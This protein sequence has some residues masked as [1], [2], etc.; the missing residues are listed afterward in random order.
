MG[1]TSAMNTSLNGLQL[2]EVS[3]DVLGNNIANAGTNGFKASTVR[4]QT[5]LA[6]TLS[7]GSRPTSTQGGTNPRQIGLGASVSVISKDFTQGSVTNSS[8]PSDLAIQGN[9]FFILNGPNGRVYSRN[10]NFSLNSNSKL[11]NDQGMFVMGY[12]VDRDFNVVKTQL[13]PMSIPIGNLNIA[14]QTTSLSLTG[15]LFPAGA[16]ATQGSITTSE[17]ITDTVAA[18]PATGTSLLSDLENS[19]GNPLFTVGQNLS[20]A[21]RKG[22]RTVEAGHLTVTATTTVDDLMQ[23]YSDT[24]GIQSGGTIPNDGVTGGQ[25]GISISGGQISIVGNAG[26]VND[27]DVTVGDLVSG[28]T[29]VPLS[30]IKSQSANGESTGTDF[31]IYD[32]LGQPIN[33]RVSS[34]LEQINPSQ[35]TYRYYIESPDNAGGVVAL[36][37]GTVDFDSLGRVSN[38]GVATFSL[39][40]S[41]TAAVSP[42]Q[43]TIDFT[44]IT[45][46]STAAAG[47]KLDLQSQNGAPPG[48]LQNFIIDE[49]GVVN[50][51]FDNGLIRP[52][53]QVVL[54]RFAN[55][56]GLIEDGSTTYKEGVSSGTPALV[57]PA[58]FGV[59]TIRAGAIELSNTDIGKSL[60]DLIVAST[61]YR[62]NARVIQSVTQLVDELLNLAR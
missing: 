52:L 19:S 55:P 6:R 62:G 28:T 51:V 53:G 56:E 13:V 33:V 23:F 10:G 20:L 14:Q 7:V 48:T 3:I 38:G 31:V 54:A 36:S 40:R 24:L 4:F 46:I 30:F 8:S 12:G 43:V 2:N 5:Q 15:A 49:S 18:A 35:T 21:P 29:V 61:N 16:P 47:S 17:V 57:E 60:V 44:G 37:N 32:S 45:G 1:L 41:D 58:T 42:M 39:D 25:P 27:I 22:G 59:G 34:V 50:G 26:S 9:G 11:V